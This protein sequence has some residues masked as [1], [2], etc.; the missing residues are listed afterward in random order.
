MDEDDVRE[1]HAKPQSQGEGVKL[2]SLQDNYKKC[3]VTGAHMI[4]QFD[5][6]DSDEES[7]EDTDDAS[8]P[9]TDNR[10]V[11]PSVQKEVSSESADSSSKEDSS[12]EASDDDDEYSTGEDASE[13]DDVS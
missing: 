3:W 9:G 13:Q 4:K 11:K 10:A 7:E 2:T 1:W 8:E 12:E 5:E 6:Q